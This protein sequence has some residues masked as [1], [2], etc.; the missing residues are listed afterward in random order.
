VK[1]EYS[2]VSIVSLVALVGLV[3]TIGG[4]G[5]SG[6]FSAYKVDPEFSARV[7]PEFQ[8]TRSGLTQ[9]IPEAEC[10]W[11]YE[12][13]GYYAYNVFTKAY[14]S[15]GEATGGFNRGAPKEYLEG[16]FEA[17]TFDESRSY[18]GIGSTGRQFITQPEFQEQRGE[19]EKT[20]YVQVEYPGQ[21]PWAEETQAGN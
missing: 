5:S 15:C 9:Q 19:L 1:N 17:R 2:I 12:L 3:L 21:V 18:V 14:E 13:R 11:V 20:Y 4:E 7:N 10:K 8:E 6:A 16:G